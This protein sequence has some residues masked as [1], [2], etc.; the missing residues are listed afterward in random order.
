M[1]TL[2]GILPYAQI[3]LSILM[4]CTI[5]LQNTGSGLGGAFG[6]GDGGGYH[7]TRRGFEK[8]LFNV[9]IVLAVLFAL[10]SFAALSI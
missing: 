1:E 2:A 7:N 5:L 10:S 4:V 6:G 3:V 8:F 9:T